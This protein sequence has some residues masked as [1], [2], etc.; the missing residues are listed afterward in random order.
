MTQKEEIRYRIKTLRS[1][2][3]SGF[4]KNI[5]LIGLK[6]ILAKNKYMI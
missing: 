3:D 2:L 4:L 5:S 1:S 6:K